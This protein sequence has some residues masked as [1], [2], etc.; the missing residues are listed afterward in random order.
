MEAIAVIFD[1][2]GVII[3]SHSVAYH[4]LCATANV[5]GCPIAVDEIK[6]WGSL[7]ARQFWKKVKDDYGLP[8]DLSELIKSYDQDK[9]I[10]MY[11]DMAPIEGVVQFIL[12]PLFA[13]KKLQNQNRILRS[14][15][16]QVK[17]SP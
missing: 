11:K 15:C 5:F 3:D 7:S 17:S 1:M 16:S 14:S 8:H 4:L 13:T 10:Q 2:D 6:S 9:E 12:K